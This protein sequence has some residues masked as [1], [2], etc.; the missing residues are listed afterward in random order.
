MARAIGWLGLRVARAIGARV[1]GARATG[2]LG[3]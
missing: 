2:W 1:I 3:L